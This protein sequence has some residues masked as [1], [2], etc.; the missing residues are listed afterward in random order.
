VKPNPDHFDLI[1]TFRVTD[2]TGPHWAHP[3]IQGGKL[4]IRHGDVLLVYNIRK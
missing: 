1:S 3:A 4:L 2:G